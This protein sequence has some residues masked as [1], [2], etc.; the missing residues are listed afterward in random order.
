MREINRCNEFLSHL[1]LLWSAPESIRDPHAPTQGT[2][3][4]DIYSFSIIL[5]E[6]IYRRGVFAT[7][8]TNV[9][10]KEIIQSIKLGNEMRPTFLGENTLHEIGNLMK[11]CWQENPNDRPDCPSILNTMKKLSKS[12]VNEMC[13]SHF[14]WCF[15]KIR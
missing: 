6:I 14:S 8:E 7:N 9:T 11:R 4:S 15:Q 1:D 2:Q 10:P 12:V 3:K 13:F 5:H